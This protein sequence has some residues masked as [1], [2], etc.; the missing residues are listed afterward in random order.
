MLSIFNDDVLHRN[1]NINVQHN[2]YSAENLQRCLILENS[3]LK[4][5]F[6]ILLVPACC[7]STQIILKSTGCYLP[8]NV[9]VYIY[10]PKYHNAYWIF[11]TNKT[12]YGNRT[13]RSRRLLLLLEYEDNL[14]CLP[15][16]VVNHFWTCGSRI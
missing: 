9:N 15:T 3:C 5:R 4:I 11:Y 16:I 14:R 1:A 13:E 10:I 12:L 2:S 6:S 7:N 8:R